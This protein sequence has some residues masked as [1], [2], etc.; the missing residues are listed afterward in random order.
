LTLSAAAE[1]ATPHVQRT[2]DETPMH[3]SAGDATPS[4]NKRWD[5]T[6]G[7]GQTPAAASQTPRR[8]RWDETP[9]GMWIMVLDMYNRVIH[10]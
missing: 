1:I 2:W 9:R 10:L 3:I 4:T 5:Q 8:N 6:P 7:G